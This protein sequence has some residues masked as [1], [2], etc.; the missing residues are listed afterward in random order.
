[1]EDF[2]LLCVY[3]GTQIEGDSRQMLHVFPLAASVRAAEAE[4]NTELGQ[5]DHVM[6]S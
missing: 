3:R 2:P 5:K 1:M 6:I 4:Q